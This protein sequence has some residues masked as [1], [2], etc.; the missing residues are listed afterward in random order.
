MRLR[1]IQGAEE[2]I[3][4]SPFVIQ[5]PKQHRGTW[6]QVFGNSRPLEIEVGMGKAVSSWKKH[7]LTR[8]SII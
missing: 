3:A 2:T 5:E 8:I 4:S 7:P 6:N 1:H